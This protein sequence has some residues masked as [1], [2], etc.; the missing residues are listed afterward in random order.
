[1]DYFAALNAFVQ[2]AEVRSF[3]VAGRKLGISSSAI[4][5]A[6]VRLEEDLGVQ[7]FHRSTRAITL[8]SEGKTFLTRCRQIFAELEDAK[9]E[10][11]TARDAPQGKL[12]IGL[13]QIGTYLMPYL[14]EF[15]QKYPLIELELDFSDTVVN[16]IED[17]FDAVI[18]IGSVN[19]SRLKMR[20]L[21][22]YS[23]QLV[24]SPE[25]LSRAGIPGHPSE[26]TKH[27]CLRYRYPN[28]NKLDAWPFAEN[29]LPLSIELPQSTIVNA[30]EP[31]YDMA[32]A[33][34]GI[35]LLPDFI[36][37]SAIDHGLLIPLFEAWLKDCRQVTLLWPSSRQTL[38]KI[39]AL[40]D[41]M[42]GQLGK[43]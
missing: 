29:A 9:M 13:P 11:L 12:R 38:P 20:A 6:V 32:I 2:S 27:T 28:S 14:I 26:L 10:L 36:T 8:T 34:I 25:Y 24:A 31:L 19:D 21:R 15:Q 41:F 16:I 7:L 3:T 42:V 40:V 33:G 37:R 43:G 30:I 23:H 4:G 17:G 18:R 39:R 35:A 1:M 5:K 22:G